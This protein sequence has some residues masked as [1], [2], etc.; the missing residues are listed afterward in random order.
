MAF[1]KTGIDWRSNWA[2]AILA[3]QIRHFLKPVTQ[4]DLIDPD[5][6]LGMDEQKA[7][8]YKNTENFLRGC[9]CSHALLWAR[10]ASASR[11]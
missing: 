11:H 2:A 8:L 1:G 5:S 6:L 7:L 10:P 3:L 9:F 4:I